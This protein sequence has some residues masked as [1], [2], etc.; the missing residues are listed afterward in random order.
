MIPAAFDTVGAFFDMLG[1]G[2]RLPGP[3]GKKLTALKGFVT[4]DICLVF[5]VCLLPDGGIQALGTSALAGSPSAGAA[6]TSSGGRAAG[7]PLPAFAE[8]LVGSPKAEV[9]T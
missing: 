7:S 4:A 3:D 1:A 6:A 2:M 5:G 9:G 8:L